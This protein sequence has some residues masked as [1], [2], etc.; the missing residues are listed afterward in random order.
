MNG[1]NGL[2]FYWKAADGAAF[3]SGAHKAWLALP[4][5]AGAPFFALDGMEA[6]GIDAVSVEGRVQ[7]GVVYN[8]NGQRVNATG[9]KRGLFIVGGKKVVVK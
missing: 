8:L 4:A 6:T 7:S 9:M 5:S 1:A 3:T 2:G